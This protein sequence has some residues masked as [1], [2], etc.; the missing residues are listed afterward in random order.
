[1]QAYFDRTEPKER[2]PV[3]AVV[4]LGLVAVPIQLCTVVVLGAALLRVLKAR[5]AGQPERLLVIAV[6]GLQVVLQLARWA[7][8]K[9]LREA[10]VDV[11]V[12]PVR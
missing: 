6:V 9:R 8:M 1:M 3:G 12:G 7:A 11:E 10:L 4:L 2:G 5:R